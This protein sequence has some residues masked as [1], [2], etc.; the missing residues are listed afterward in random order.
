MSLPSL[1]DQPDDLKKLCRQLRGQDF[2]VVDTEFIRERTYYPKLC[3]IQVAGPSTIACV[4]FLA[5]DDLSPLTSLLLDPTITKVLH[6]A[7]QDFEIFVQLTG[8]VP[9]P[10]FDTQVA[11]NLCGLGDQEGLAAVAARLL[12]VSVDKSHTRTDW[13]RRPLSQRQL[14]YA[15]DDVRYLVPIY[16]ELRE[17]LYEQDRTAWLEEDCERLLDPS[18]YVVEPATAWQRLG[19]L[20]GLP[21]ASFH[22]A[23]LLANWREERAIRLDRPRGWV[24]RDD[25]LMR[26]AAALP[27][28]TKALANI[29]GMPR[30]LLNK[31]SRTL[32]DLIAAAGACDDPAPDL[33]GP[34]NGDQ[35]KLV[36][37]MMD[38]VRQI[39]EEIGV[40]SATLA[41]RRDVT[42]LVR[43]DAAAA[44]LHGWRR[45]AIGEQLLALSDGNA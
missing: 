38:R 12:S 39:A 43:G 15:I 33:P 30:P 10:L 7:R 26:I 40:S 2:I 1:I 11:A 27:E 28:S 5:L 29:T 14:Q 13:S 18:L 37:R 3:L 21:Q 8:E 25:V 6:A 44:P 23:R 45:A 19:G 9:A 4:D 36:G 20:A 22:A 34:L 35:R 16:M 17:R 32:L 24:L 41:T 31:E 42:A